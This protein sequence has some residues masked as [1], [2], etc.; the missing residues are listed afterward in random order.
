MVGD[1]KTRFLI[2]AR[3][4]QREGMDPEVSSDAALHALIR[5]DGRGFQICI[6][7]S[8]GGSVTAGYVG[9]E[10]DIGC[11]AGTL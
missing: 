10:P 3:R 7:A 11:G 1:A 4:E 6:G 8:Q 5:V 9:T 2:D